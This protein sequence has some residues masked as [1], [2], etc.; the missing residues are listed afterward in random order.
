MERRS[1]P[2][3]LED[4]PAA[5]LYERYAATVFAYLRRRLPSREDAEAK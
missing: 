5:A 1:G 3:S 4:S 2:A